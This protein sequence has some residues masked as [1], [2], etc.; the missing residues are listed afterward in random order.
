MAS[1]KARLHAAVKAAAEAARNNT[2]YYIPAE[3]EIFF[4]E[5][6]DP[7]G[8]EILLFFPESYLF[9]A[10]AWAGDVRTMSEF[11]SQLSNI[12]YARVRKHIRME[13]PAYWTAPDSIRY[14]VIEKLSRVQV[15]EIAN[16]MVEFCTENTKTGAYELTYEEIMDWFKVS[17]MQLVTA[18]E[19]ILDMLYRHH[20]EK[21]LGNIYDVYDR[22]IDA[23]ANEREV[24]GFEITFKPEFCPNYEEVE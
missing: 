3:A 4:G 19:A 14:P 5:G 7:D 16:W 21:I 13:C 24:V 23:S 1:Y 11:L 9:N 18:H 17:Y 12:L 10:D 6:T 20:R 2:M 8:D 22:K 15:C